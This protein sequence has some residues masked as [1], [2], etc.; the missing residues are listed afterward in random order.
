[1]TSL[2][3]SQPADEAVGVCTEK[4]ALVNFE[5]LHELGAHAQGVQGRATLT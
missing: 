2:A 5:H 3:P 1:M 4:R